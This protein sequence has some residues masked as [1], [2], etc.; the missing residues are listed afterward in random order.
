M[1]RV[2]W[3]IPALRQHE[4]IKSDTEPPEESIM[5]MKRSLQFTLILSL[6]SGCA[7]QKLQPIDLASVS[8]VQ[9][10]IKEQVGVYM[11]AASYLSLADRNYGAVVVL[12]G[13]PIEIPA[14]EFS[15]GSGRV[16]FR[17]SAIKAELVTSLDKTTAAKLGLT[18]PVVPVTVGPSA[19]ISGDTLNAQT[20]DYNLWPL[21]ASDQ[22]FLPQIKHWPE[23]SPDYDALIPALNKAPIAIALLELRNA[24]ILAATAKDYSTDRL[25][26]AQPCFTD[27]NPTSPSA[28][29]GNSF[30]LQLQ[31]TS[32][33]SVG[34]TMGVPTLNLS[35]TQDNKSVSG[36]TL[37][38]T[39]VQR[40]VKHLQILRDQATK[41]CSFPYDGK[42]TATSPPELPKP[43]TAALCVVATEALKAVTAPA[44]AVNGRLELLESHLEPL[45]KMEGGEK[46]PAVSPARLGDTP[47]PPPPSA[48]DQARQLVE[49]ARDFSARG[50]AY[51]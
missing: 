31:I 40:G 8:T 46:K 41:D 4:K 3:T 30:K 21:A 33:P 25:R 6:M 34:I 42:L 9:A 18:L 24:L 11:Q 23:S 1:W 29:A 7:T 17:I 27:Y 38:V 43:T 28:D 15:C 47:A 50:I 49:I 37:T 26:Q 44:S 32:D 20:L 48:C 45:C 10:K 36:N 22:A 12:N 39:F 13:K 51:E 19:G 16:D 5:V 2:G 35:F 14:T